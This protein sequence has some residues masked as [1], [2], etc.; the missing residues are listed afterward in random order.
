MTG[1]REDWKIREVFL[2]LTVILF[3]LATILIAGVVNTSAA[4][5]TFNEE[6][7]I[8][9][10]T[11]VN[12]SL[13]T[14]KVGNMLFACTDNFCEVWVP[15]ECVCDDCPEC[16][17]INFTEMENNI[18]ALVQ[19]HNSSNLEEEDKIWFETKISEG[20]SYSAGQVDDFLNESL[21]PQRKELE[22]RDI[23]IAILEDRLRE[24][25]NT[26]NLLGEELLQC[27]QRPVL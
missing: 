23:S 19:G 12:N 27:S 6:V 8:T 1:N 15:V 10:I 22:D 18:T 25:N 2:I 9:A 11:I 24:Q 17:S 4:T 14:I 20:A 3:A 5:T 21:M 7:N 13:E 26:I 16:P